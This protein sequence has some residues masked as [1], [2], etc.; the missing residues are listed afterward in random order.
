MDWGLVPK[1]EKEKGKKGRGNEGR[2]RA[3]HLSSSRTSPVDSYHQPTVESRFSYVPCL[4]SSGEEG[5][6]E[7]REEEGEEAG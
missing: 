4:V 6:K 5:R 3:P 2:E 1:R 7:G